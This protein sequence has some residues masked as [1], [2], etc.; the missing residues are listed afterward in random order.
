MKCE[1]TISRPF[2]REKDKS[3]PIN[4]QPNKVLRFSKARQQHTFCHIVGQRWKQFSEQVINILTL[5]RTKI[6]IFHVKKIK[7]YN[8]YAVQTPVPVSVG[9]HFQFSM[10]QTFQFP[11][12]LLDVKLRSNH[13]RRMLVWQGNAKSPC[14]IKFIFIDT[15][16][17][18]Y[19]LEIQKPEK[20]NK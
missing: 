17:N 8:N 9:M 2:R 6:H 16:P 4:M 14:N 11:I 12:V 19:K 1:S 13:K 3:M 18:R 5:K 20:E 10:F 7:K 15:N